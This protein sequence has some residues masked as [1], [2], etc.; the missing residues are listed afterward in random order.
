MMPDGSASVLTSLKERAGVPL[1]KEAFAG[2]QQYRINDQQ[3]FIRKVM[4]KQR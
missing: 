4:F 3:D 1:V 2:A